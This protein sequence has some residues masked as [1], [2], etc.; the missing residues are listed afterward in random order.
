MGS[1]A[2][3]EKI[4]PDSECARKLCDNVEQES[5]IESCFRFIMG[6]MQRRRARWTVRRPAGFWE[7][8]SRGLAFCDSTL[9]ERSGQ[10]MDIF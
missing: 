2:H 6:A 1:A 8:T 10:V 5:E 3:G 9:V 4:G 7:R